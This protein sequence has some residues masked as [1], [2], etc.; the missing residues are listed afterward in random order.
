MASGSASSPGIP[1][2]S[3]LGRTFSSSPRGIGSP[4]ANGVNRNGGSHSRRRPRGRS[5]VVVRPNQRGQPGRETQLARLNAAVDAPERNAELI[6][7][8]AVRQIVLVVCKEHPA[9]NIWF[10]SESLVDQL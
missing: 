10:V 1:L 5:P 6:N 4:L 2:G 3:T 7:D 8:L 9:L